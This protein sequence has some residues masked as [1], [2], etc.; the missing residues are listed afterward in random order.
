MLAL[1]TRSSFWPALLISPLLSPQHPWEVGYAERQWLAQVHL[2]SFTTKQVTQW[3]SPQILAHP[4]HYSLCSH[5]KMYSYFMKF[6]S[7]SYLPVTFSLKFTLLSSIIVLK[8][9]LLP[10]TPKMIFTH[11]Q[12]CSIWNLPGVNF[13]NYKF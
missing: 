2:M 6:M 12:Y 11:M 9:H 13:W 1:S 5:N 3:E 7:A 4:N 10:P 8:F